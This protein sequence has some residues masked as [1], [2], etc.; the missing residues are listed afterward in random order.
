MTNEDKLAE[1]LRAI[2]AH[3]LD[4]NS[5]LAVSIVAT[6]DAALAALS[7]A[8]EPAAVAYLERLVAGYPTTAFP[9]SHPNAADIGSF[10][11]SGLA[12]QY[13]KTIQVQD[14]HPISPVARCA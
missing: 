3:V 6:C 1:A 7:R 14:V 2:R 13:L 11:F 10:G 12:R 9:P 5:A 8:A 4:L